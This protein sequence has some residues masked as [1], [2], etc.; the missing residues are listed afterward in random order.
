VKT[1]KNKP[2]TILVSLLLVSILVF[3]GYNLFK[4]QPSPIPKTITH[5]IS[6]NIFIPRIN[7]AWQLDKTKTSYNA[8]TGVITT[9][10]TSNGNKITMTQQNV[11][12]TFKDVPTYYPALLNKLH[13]YSEIQTSIGTIALTR[14][15]EFKGG[16]SAVANINNTL[17][18]LHPASDLTDQQWTAFFNN[19]EILK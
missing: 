18:F 2:I 13:E 8:D 10:L 3:A 11:P 7:S 17:M 6:Y 9:E 12:Q 14:P 5:K 4:P 16:Q 1:P 19:L 15:E